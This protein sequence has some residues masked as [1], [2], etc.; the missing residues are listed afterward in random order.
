MLQP[1]ARRLA[2]RMVPPCRAFSAG[3]PTES[4]RPT[5]DEPRL[6]AVID[7]AFGELMNER[8]LK[9]LGTQVQHAYGF[10]RRVK[11]PLEMYLTSMASAREYPAC[12]RALSD[13]FNGRALGERGVTDAS[14]ACESAPIQLRDEPPDQ[15]WDRDE[16]VWLSPDA[17]VPL[18]TLDPRK[19]YVIGGLV[20]RSVIKYHTLKYARRKGL[21]VRRLPI[22]E[23]CPEPSLHKIFTLPPILRLLAGVHSG[24]SWAEAFMASVPQRAVR[25]NSA[26]GSAGGRG[27]RTLKQERP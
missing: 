9:S 16:L 5:D 1:L 11:R 23:H 19:V 20:D 3:A 21:T 17:T 25:R 8:E 10:N 15:L 6:R 26:H 24:E 18:L 2:R 12:M 22:K 27:P 13:R 4:S 14:R 7:M